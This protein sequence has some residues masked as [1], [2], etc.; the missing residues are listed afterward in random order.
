MKV[1]VVLLLFVILKL[2]L[3]GEDLLDKNF[4]TVKFIRVCKV[5][6]NNNL[7]DVL[8]RVKEVELL[9]KRENLDE[10]AKKHYEKEIKKNAITIEMHSKYKDKILG[11][12]IIEKIEVND[13]LKNNL[14]SFFRVL[15]KKSSIHS[16]NNMNTAGCLFVFRY[17]IEIENQRCS[18]FYR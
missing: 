1:K 11:Y 17:V 5:F 13:I 9:S 18:K 2:N 12:P 3:V 15:Q 7:D 14:H 16:I 4:D 10:K 8:K 6:P